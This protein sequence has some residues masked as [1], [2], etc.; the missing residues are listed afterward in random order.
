MLLPHCLLMSRIPFSP[1]WF[2]KATSRPI[3]IRYWLAAEVLHKSEDSS[4]G[5]DACW[6]V[7]FADRCQVP[8]PSHGTSTNV[9]FTYLRSTNTPT[10]GQLLHDIDAP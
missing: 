5:N 6:F 9:K 2:Y 1:Y 7:Y 3:T 10:M 8:E 4:N